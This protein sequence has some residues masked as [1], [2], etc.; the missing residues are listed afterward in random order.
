MAHSSH[1]RYGAHHFDTHY[2]TV[3]TPKFKIFGAKL[4]QLSTPSVRPCLQLGSAP[5]A[6][7]D[8]T[9]ERVPSS[10][11]RY[12]S[13][14]KASLEVSMISLLP[15]GNHRVIFNAN[16]SGTNVVIY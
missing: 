16:F 13:S 7:R 2:V 9:S 6:H 11:A 12:S 10:T 1:V 15:T 14:D 3:C 5:L 8:R 4:V